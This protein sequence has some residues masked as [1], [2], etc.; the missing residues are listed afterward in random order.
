MCQQ[1]SAG[2]VLEALG[3]SSR[4]G[5][6]QCLEA[7][8]VAQLMVLSSTFKAH[9]VASSRLCPPLT[10]LPPSYKGACDYP[11][12]PGQSPQLRILI[13]TCQ[14]PLATG[15]GNEDG[16]FWGP[17]ILLTTFTKGDLE[18]VECSGGK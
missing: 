18:G 5:L 8:C 9:S 12:N 4:P 7:A 15:S 1:E 6:F 10:L 17:V 11:D 16:I 3:E 13:H 2:L 14:V